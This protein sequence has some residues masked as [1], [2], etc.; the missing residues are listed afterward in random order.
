MN[1]KTHGEMIGEGK[2]GVRRKVYADPKA[3]RVVIFTDVRSVYY[4]AEDLLSPAE[5]SDSLRRYFIDQFILAFAAVRE[6]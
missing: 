2:K 4:H 6:F 5:I 1:G 3:A